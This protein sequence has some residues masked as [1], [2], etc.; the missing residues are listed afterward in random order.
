PELGQL[1]E[2]GLPQNATHGCHARIVRD[3]E[4]T[5]PP[6][7]LSLLARLNERRD[8]FVM[9]RV[10]DVRPHRPEFE[11][12]ERLHPVADALLAEKD[13][14]GGGQLDE[15]ADDDEERRKNREQREARTQVDGA[16]DRVVPS[17]PPV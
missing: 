5:V 13:R 15:R 7:F 17:P 4:E 1:V 2:T 16:L 12:G 11:D 14:T 3:L 8:E 9:N 10:A 6:G